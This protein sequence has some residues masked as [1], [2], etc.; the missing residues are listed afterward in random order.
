M[1]DEASARLEEPL[2]EARQRPALD[3][4]R[5]DQPAQQIAEVVGDDP[6]QQADLV[7]AEAVARETRSMGSFLALFDPCSAVPRW[8]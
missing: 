6:E 3:G 8:L 4:N 1:P 7:R 2:L 5:Q